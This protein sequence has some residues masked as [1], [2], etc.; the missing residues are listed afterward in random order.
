[1]ATEDD[2]RLLRTAPSSNP[3]GLDLTVEE[4]RAMSA[5]ELERLF[6]FASLDDV[7]LVGPGH[8][9]RAPREC[10]WYARFRPKPKN[11]EPKARK[12]DA[13]ELVVKV[14]QRGR[15]GA[16][17]DAGGADVNPKRIGL[18]AKEPDAARLE[19]LV[20]LARKQ[21][22]RRRATNWPIE[23]IQSLLCFDLC[24]KYI[25]VYLADPPEGVVENPSKKSTRL[26]YRSEVRAF[27]AA[28]PELEVGD[29]GDWIGAEYDRR[30]AH[31]RPHSRSLDLRTAKRALKQGLILVGVPPTYALDFSVPAVKMPQKTAWTPEEYD[32]LRAAAAGWLF[33]ADGTPKMVPGPDSPVQERRSDYSVLSREAWR[34]AIAF[35]PYTGSRGG[36]LPPTRWVP[37]EVEPKDGEPLKDRPW[38]EIAE[39]EIVFHRD[40]EARYDGNK[41]RRPNIIPEEFAPTVRGWF[42]A[43]MA[44]GYEFVFHKPDG[45]RYAGRRLEKETFAQIVQDAGLGKRRIPHHLK[46]LCV[47]WADEA[48]I[49]R[50]TLAVHADTDAR[51]LARKYGDPL[52]MAQLKEAAEEMKQAAW[53]ERGRRKAKVAELFERG[54]DEQGAGEQ[55]PARRRRAGK[56]TTG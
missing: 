10:A 19:A 25:A 47:Q 21:G 51:T 53:R 48:R 2:A 37:P 8:L 7:P 46:D 33:H 35:L 22:R 6:G 14:P 41:R 55:G 3:D 50:N 40:G 38:I 12:T 1:M 45:S 24:Q 36:R 31:R 17:P 39:L 34:R 43:D 44:R 29:I 4:A 5:E 28:F 15:N 56:G 23:R 26:T 52:R 13:Y 18:D 20:Y 27:Q 49:D 9:K 32:R 30:A 42:E 11:S 16:G 54:R